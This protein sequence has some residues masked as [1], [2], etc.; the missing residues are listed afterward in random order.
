[1]K[2]L[3]V[4]ALAI[5]MLV[6]CFAVA[7]SAT[8]YEKN[9]LTDLTEKLKFSV[10]S[11]AT[12]PTIDG[13]VSTDEYFKIEYSKDN[14]YYIADEQDGADNVAASLAL[15][16]N[17]TV[18][19][20]ATYDADNMYFAW[21]VPVTNDVYVSHDKADANRA[22]H[23]EASLL[24]RIGDEYVISEGN[25]EAPKIGIAR[26]KSNGQTIATMFQTAGTF[27]D[28]TIADLGYA[29]SYTNG[30]LTYEM[31]IPASVFHLSMNDKFNAGEKIAF[32]WMAT[33]GGDPVPTNN[34]WLKQR[35][36]CLGS[37]GGDSAS[38]TY[39]TLLELTG[40]PGGND[41]GNTG[42]TGNTGNAGN[43]GNTGNTGSTNNKNDETETKAPE[44]TAATEPATETVA[45]SQA[46]GDEGGCGSSVAVGGMAIVA[47][48]SAGAIVVRR[49]RK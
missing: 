2:K 19:F 1:M 3:L 41:S 48:M 12:A 8:V 9:N 16:K 20:Y 29:T 24:I 7:A 10:D 46:D 36:I 11:K 31:R 43:T 5:I 17:T 26:L 49:K 15:M 14:L 35:M 42:N 18:S 25:A 28:A 40:T 30:V 33:I 4:L 37:G 39:M 23:A 13:T 27:A 44:T 21:E 6:S 34:Q 47:V 22:M 32:S 45:E 38:T